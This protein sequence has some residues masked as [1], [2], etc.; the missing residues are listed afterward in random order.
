MTVYKQLISLG[1]DLYVFNAEQ[2]T[3]LKV[4]IDQNHTLAIGNT[5]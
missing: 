1:V 5:N 3:A 4:A 2:K